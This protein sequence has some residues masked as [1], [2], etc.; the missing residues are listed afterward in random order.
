MPDDDTL[1]EMVR[2]MQKFDEAPSAVDGNSASAPSPD[3]EKDDKVTEH[4]TPE[5][6][7]A[8]ARRCAERVFGRDEIY[9]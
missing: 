8:Y 5:L 1:D 2:R 4:P 6:M 3:V 7:F 9:I